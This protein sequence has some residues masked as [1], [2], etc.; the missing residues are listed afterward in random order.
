M[1]AVAFGVDA[2]AVVDEPPR[3]IA[4]LALITCVAM[5]QTVL[6]RSD[7]KYRAEAVIDPLTGM[8]NRK[9]LATRVAELE[10]QSRLSRDPIGLIVADIDHFKSINDGHGHAAGDAVL[11]EVAYELRKQ[12]RAF[13]LAYRIGGEE[14][15]IVL[16]GAGRQQALQLAEEL[17]ARIAAWPWAG[18]AVTMSLGVS[19]SAEG[20]A[21]DY[22][23]SFKAAD[24]ALYEA[25]R[26]GRNRVCSVDDTEQDG[27]TEL[28]SAAGLVPHFE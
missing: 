17:R 22:E 10:Q 28:A 18:H 8:L 1:I 4:P 19:A 12:L 21:F 24:A 13:D 11:K 27:S 25:K 26:T 7:I 6:M 14:F 3:L 5:F 9:A 20:D 2:Q 23:S 15:L 16:P